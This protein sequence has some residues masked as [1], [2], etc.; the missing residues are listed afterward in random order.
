MK[1]ATGSASLEIQ[2]R[3]IRL[4]RFVAGN[5]DRVGSF[6][7]PRQTRAELRLPVQIQL[8]HPFL[9]DPGTGSRSR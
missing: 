3:H 2:Y 9:L 4:R 5:G 8:R 1:P 7:S 6:L